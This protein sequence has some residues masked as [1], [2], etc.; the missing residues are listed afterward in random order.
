MG[1]IRLKLAFV[2][3]FCAF[4]SLSGYGQNWNEI[5]RQ[6]KTQ[7]RYLLQQIAALEMYTGY[8]KKGYEL[9]G[10]GLQTIRDISNGEFS[11]HNA[12]I[13]GLKEVSPV[14]RND[15]RVLEIIEMQV[16]IGRALGNL[17]SRPDLNV[18]TQLYIQD[19]RENLWE[20]SLK[21]LEELLM[22]ITSGS[23]EM[24]EGERI[25][26]L[27]KVYLSMKEKMAFNRHFTTEVSHYS[28]QKEMEIRS[29]EKL[30]ES[31]GIMEQN[32]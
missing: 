17:R 7:Q 11:L 20:E 26:R 27:N 22:V 18:S 29:I 31:Y 12:F 32:H 1:S 9:V 24:G 25:E 16:N 23:V 8:L 28:R 21:D 14:V 15:V 3:M 5:F 10:G 2:L 19:M 6:K 13:S 4:G 30:K